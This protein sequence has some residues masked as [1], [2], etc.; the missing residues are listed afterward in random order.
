MSRIVRPSGFVV[1]TNSD[2]V[3]VG[4]EGGSESGSL[5][6]AFK[7]LSEMYLRAPWYQTEA[8]YLD[9]GTSGRVKG[10]WVQV[11][12]AMV[13]VARDRMVELLE[14]EGLEKRA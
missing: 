8:H 5:G 3:F 9:V 13:R 1:E 14:V 11:D 7:V 10:F 12:P 2:T 6:I 4:F